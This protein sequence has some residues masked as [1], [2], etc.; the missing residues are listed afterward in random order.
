MYYEVCHYQLF[1]DMSA[2]CRCVSCLQMCQLL[3]DVLLLKYILRNCSIIMGR[4]K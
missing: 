3:A 2:V 1:A 4:E